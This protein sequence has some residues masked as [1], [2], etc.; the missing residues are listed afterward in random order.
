MTDL[1]AATAFVTT[2]GR[3]LERRRLDRLVNGT[4]PDGLLAALA[5]YRN[6]D[7]GFGWGLEPDLPTPASQP[8]GALHAF[9]VLEQASPATSPLGAS[10]CDW[11]ASVSLPGSGLP[12]A[13]RDAAG[14][15]VAPW[16]A[17]ADP[18]APSLHL[19]SAVCAQAH[20]VRVHDR[21]V[22]DHPWLQRA[23]DW[24]WTTLL[25]RSEPEG[26]YELRFVLDLLDAVVDV[27]P[28]AAEQLARFAAFVPASGE[29]PVEGG[30]ADERLRPL[31]YAPRPGRP[32]RE[33]VAPQAI[34]RDLDRLAS[35]QR[36]DGGW[37]VDFRINSP[38]AGLAWRG[39]ATVRA[40][41]VLH[42]N[43]RLAVA[44]A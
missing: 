19:T 40:V 28:Q 27:V 14:P 35:G 3:L 5:A 33:H 23:T 15:G 39:Y 36:P 2:H 34:A 8:V 21:A 9:E 41:S 10:L 6:E 17:G 25:G 26:A 20:R 44:P 37:D 22:A 1:D 4:S 30:L 11:L 38:A 13:L 31:D 42:A 7:G 43:D 12:F 18:A 16:W 32:V 29:L 24:C